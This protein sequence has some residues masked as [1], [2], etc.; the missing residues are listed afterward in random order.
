M[1]FVE[2]KIKFSKTKGLVGQ[3]KNQVPISSNEES[4]FLQPEVIS[5]VRGNESLN[6]ILRADCQELGSEAFS[7]KAITDMNQE[8]FE[9]ADFGSEPE[10]E[11]DRS[12]REVDNKIIEKD[13]LISDYQIPVSANRLN[14]RAQ[15]KS[16]IYSFKMKISYDL[17]SSGTRF[18]NG[19]S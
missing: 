1:P 6:N 15:K 5:K 11:N 2:S 9:D 4:K 16:N 7:M 12:F 13:E 19:I 18:L 14:G 10:Q 8:I 3:N 17:I